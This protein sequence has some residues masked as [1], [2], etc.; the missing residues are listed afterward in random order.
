MS[1]QTLKYLGNLICLFFAV[2]TFVIP[3]ATYNKA[4]AKETLWVLAA[5]AL[6]VSPLAFVIQ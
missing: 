2:C 4:S 5:G 6:V 1:D 3:A